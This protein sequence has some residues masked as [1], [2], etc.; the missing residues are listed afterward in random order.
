MSK[1]VIIGIVIGLII[2]F[3]VWWLYK[4]FIYFPHAKVTSYTADRINFEVPGELSSSITKTDH[5]LGGSYYGRYAYSV[6]MLPND[7]FAFRVFEIQDPSKE[8][9]NQIH[10][11][12]SPPRYLTK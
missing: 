2:L 4:R 8:V 6:D 10:S 5:G 11:F 9:V 12:N 7:Q 3:L 1:K